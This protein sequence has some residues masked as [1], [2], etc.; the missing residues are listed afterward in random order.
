MEVKENDNIITNNK[1][2]NQIILEKDENEIIEN[3]ESNNI[4]IES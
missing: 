2:L 1:N 3:N 4:K